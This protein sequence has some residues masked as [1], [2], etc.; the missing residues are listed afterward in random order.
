MLGGEEVGL[1][2][3][4]LGFGLGFVERGEGAEFDFFL[5]LGDELLASLTAATCTSTFW[6]A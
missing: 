2:G 4:D 6:R 1:A 5:V 3:G